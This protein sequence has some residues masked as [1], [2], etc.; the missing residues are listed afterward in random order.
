MT[1]LRPF[2]PY[3]GGKWRMVPKYQPPLHGIIVEP[4]AGAAGYSTRYAD[5]RVVLVERDPVVAALWRYLISVP[6]SEILRLPIEVEDARLLA[7][8]EEARSLIGFWLNVGTPSPRNKPSAWMRAGMRAGTHAASFWGPEIRQRI[9]S[10]VG[11]IRHWHVIEGG[12]EEAP[13]CRATWFV[14]PPYAN[15]AGERYRCSAK[16]IDFAALGEW[17]RSRPGQTIVCENEGANWLPFKHLAAF[18]GA[19]GNNRTNKRG[20]VVWCSE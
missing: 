3:Y 7:V 20:E 17:C 2:W 6:S 11:K 1:G 19:R 13:P 18:S 12:Y 5:R 14:D 9:A 15:A 16:A 8:P 4:F 10:Q